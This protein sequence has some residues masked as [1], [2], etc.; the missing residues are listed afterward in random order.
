[1]FVNIGPEKPLWGVANYV[2]IHLHIILITSVMPISFPGSLVLLPPG[3][4][5]KI[6]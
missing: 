5:D 2:Y 1:M 6:R 3:A 4:S